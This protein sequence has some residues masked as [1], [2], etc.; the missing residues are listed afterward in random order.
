MKAWLA[1]T[2]TLGIHFQHTRG[3]LLRI[4]LGKQ[5]FVVISDSQSTKL[6]VT[7]FRYLV[8]VLAAPSTSTNFL[9]ASQILP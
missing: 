4:V 9:A 6:C 3:I 5:M 7:L 1:L 2:H 8:N